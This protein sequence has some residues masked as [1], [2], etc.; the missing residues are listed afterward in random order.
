MLTLRLT[1]LKKINTITILLPM[2]PIWVPK[3]RSPQPSSKVKVS[4]FV[5]LP[6]N[7]AVR[8]KECA[9]CRRA[10]ADYEHSCGVAFHKVCIEQYFDAISSVD[11]AER[12]CPHCYGPVPLDLEHDKEATIEVSPIPDEVYNQ[13]LELTDEF[14]L[15]LIDSRIMDVSVFLKSPSKEQFFVS[16]D[17]GY[18]PK[19]PTFSFSD[20]LLIN[21]EGLDELLEELSNWDPE[22]PPRLKDV[23][24][25]IES[26]IKPEEKKAQEIERDNL[27]SIED[28]KGKEKVLDEKQEVEFIE[29]FPE[30]E[31]VEVTS[32]NSKVKEEGVYEVEEILPATF[33]EMDITYESEIKEAEP[34]QGGFENEEAIQQYLDLNNSFSVELVG[35]EIYHVIV[36]LSCLDA[37]IYNIYP[38][39]INF[40][41][42]P[43]KPSMT[44]TDELLVR[45]RGLDEILTKFRHWGVL[46][47]ENIVDILQKLEVKLVEDSMVESE[48]EVI[49]R[50][51]KTK[52]L[53]KNRLVVTLST[54][55][56][57]FFEVELDLKHYPSPPIIY[58]PGDLKDLEI[59]E[60]EGIKKWP[61]KPQKRI[62]DV[63]RS[64]SHSINDLHRIEFEESLLRMVAE[65][66]E[67]IN[68]EY[69]VVIA[70]PKSEGDMLGGEAS[71]KM[72]INLKIKVPKAYPLMPP[73]IEADADDEEVK[74]TAQVFLADMLKS[75][76]P[77]MFLADAV[78]RL[79]L[80]LSNNS[81]FKC[82]ICGQRECP[83]CGFPLLT[84]P[85]EESEEICEIPCIQCKRPYHVHCL[86]RSIQDG[87]KECAYCLTDLNQFFRRSLYVIAS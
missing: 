22:F 85:L 70:V 8:T 64:L 81:L 29:V 34:S 57:R 53:T 37:G 26:R 24:H 87:I 46:I 55:G 50:E 33:F 35:D 11:G 52:R 20:E 1:F 39:T 13:Y 60:L 77:S 36:Y 15:A 17:F 63:L 3:K 45:I 7:E 73:E 12:I 48:I 18:Y 76:A 2:I 74:R 82:L 49:K 23:I 25:T 10:N 16:I 27:S 84:V 28:G 61:E 44:F 21:I 4:E 47:S 80:S 78:N 51:Y 30:D 41:D 68:G 42:Y 58:L 6:K 32:E 67:I 43:K 66:F 62:M 5:E 9:I 14:S 83:I 59:D 56:R 71:V 79:S 86:K 38:I 65:K 54:Y 31:F 19:K 75:W 69:N 40:R 72:H